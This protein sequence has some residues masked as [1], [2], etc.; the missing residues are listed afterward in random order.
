MELDLSIELS[1]L[2]DDQIIDL[3]RAIASEALKRDANITPTREQLEKILVEFQAAEKTRIE[4]QWKTLEIKAAV[5]EAI[6]RWGYK[7]DFEIRSGNRSQYSCI[8]IH[9]KNC[10]RTWEWKLYLSAGNE[11]YRKGEMIM[12]GGDNWFYDHK[13]EL[14]KLLIDIS[15][16][17]DNTNFCILGAG[18]PGVT[19]SQQHLE[20]YLKIVGINDKP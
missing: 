15:K 19:P 5:V 13:N 8:Y 6:R 20:R 9:N 16:T 2:S 7:D 10:I 11:W 1:S 4:N 12:R 14:K 3:L 17:W 18:Y